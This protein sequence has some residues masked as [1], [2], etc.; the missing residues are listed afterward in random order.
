MFTDPV[1]DRADHPA[2]LAG[3]M[4]DRFNQIGDRGFTVSAG[5]T[6]A[7]DLI[8]RI[9]IKPLPYAMQKIFRIIHIQN[10]HIIRQWLDI[11]QI[12]CSLVLTIILAP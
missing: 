11:L 9:T 6:D 5:D 7:L 2:T 10:T 4:N 3:R 12:A 1:I 8:G